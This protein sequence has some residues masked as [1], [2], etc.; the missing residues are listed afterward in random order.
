MNQHIATIVV[1]I[2]RYH[3]T[4]CKQTEFGTPEEKHE[5]KSVCSMANYISVK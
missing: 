2:I 1:Y 3:K 4:S 5:N